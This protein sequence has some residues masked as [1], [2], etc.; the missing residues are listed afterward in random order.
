MSH[1]AIVENGFNIG[2]RQGLKPGDRVLLSPPLFWSFGCANALPAA[3]THGAA[4]VLLEKFEPAAALEAIEKNQCTALYTLPGMTSAMLR[5]PSFTPERVKS[6]RTGLTIGSEQDVREAATALGASEICNIYG[7]TETYGNC[8]VTW[9]H[10]PLARRAACQGPPLPGNTLRFVDVETG[11]TVAPGEPGLVEIKGYVTP[12]YT[13]ASTN[14][15]AAAF[16]S[17]SYYRTGDI[18]RLDATGAF[19]FVGRS[20]EMIKRAG[21]NVSPAEVEE[22]LRRHPAVA[23]AGVAGIPDRERGELVIAFVVLNPSAQVTADELFQHCR[24]VASKYKVPDRIEIRPSLPLTPTG[25][26]MRRELKSTAVELA[27]RAGKAPHG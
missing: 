17:D 21:I 20:T 7:A 5:H 22:I 9:H 11:A 23:L 10:W 8:C 2:E 27:A 14:Q 4:V 24:T 13:N 12:G 15:N 25:K 6:L 3:F 18:G 1:C 16:T 19:V 26:L